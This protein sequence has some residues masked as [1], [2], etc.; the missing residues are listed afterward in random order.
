MPV[1]IGWYLNGKSFP[2]FLGISTS[3]AGR[4][5]SILTIESVQFEHMG[6]YSCK[7]ENQAGSSEYTVELK[8]NGYYNAY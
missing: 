7:A 8:V 6:N 3:A 4:R 5:G 1:E 2:N